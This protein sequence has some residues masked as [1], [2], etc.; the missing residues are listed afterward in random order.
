MYDIVITVEAC[1]RAGTRVDVAWAVETHGFSSQDRSQALALTPGGGRVGAVL[2]GSADAQL[3]DLAEQGRTRR[4]VAL[5]VGEVDAMVAGLSCGGD[6]RCLIVPAADL[7]AELWPRLRDREPVCLVSTLDGETVTG[8]ALFTADTI[9][10][11]GPD[12]TELFRRGVSTAAVSDHEVVTVLWP[13]PRW[14]SSG[15][16][17]SPRRW[18]ASRTARLAGPRDRPGR[19][20]H[21]R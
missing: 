16:A 12:A 18:P 14:S 6:A 7:P 10:E 21:R 2:S 19:G 20:G 3:A 4:L 1:L 8:T 15:P 17:R 9:A 13:C 11:A 5:T